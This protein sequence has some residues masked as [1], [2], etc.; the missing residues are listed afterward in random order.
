MNGLGT[1]GRSYFSYADGVFGTTFQIPGEAREAFE[2]MADEIIDWRLAEYLDRGGVGA[3]DTPLAE[4]AEGGQ[5]V[6]VHDEESRAETPGS[7]TRC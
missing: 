1:G 7:R 4:V 3:A 5:A 6:F 2:G